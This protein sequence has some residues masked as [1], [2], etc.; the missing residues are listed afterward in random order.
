MVHPGHRVADVQVA[1][2]AVELPAQPCTVLGPSHADAAGQ[3]QPARQFVASDRLVSAA[4][5]AGPQDVGE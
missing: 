1:P 5:R 2:Q 3:R 4:Q